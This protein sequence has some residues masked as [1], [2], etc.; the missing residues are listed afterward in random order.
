MCCVVL[1][2]NRGSNLI[3]IGPFRDSFF[4][5]LP[6]PRIT[7]GPV[8]LPWCSCYPFLAKNSPALPKVRKAVELKEK[9]GLG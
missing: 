8:G 2:Q 3:G 5:H 9:A 6:N 4:N 1:V 7:P